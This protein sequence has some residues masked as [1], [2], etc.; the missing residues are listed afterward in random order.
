MQTV[1]EKDPAIRSVEREG[2]KNIIVEK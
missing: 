1:L 2:V